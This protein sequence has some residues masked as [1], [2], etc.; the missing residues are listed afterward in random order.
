MQHCLW[1]QAN[2]AWGQPSRGLSY[3]YKRLLISNSAAWRWGAFRA[4][5]RKIFSSLFI[6]SWIFIQ[7]KLNKQLYDIS[8]LQILWRIAPI[9]APPE[10]LNPGTIMFPFCSVSTNDERDSTLSSHTMSV[11]ATCLVNW[12]VFFQSSVHDTAFRGGHG[13]YWRLVKDQMMAKRQEANTDHI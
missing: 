2:V 13:F 11:L 7:L 9:I 12:T 1:R 8:S 3:V 10:K 4:T 5:G 6:F